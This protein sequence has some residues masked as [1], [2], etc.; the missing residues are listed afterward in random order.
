MCEHTK[1][2]GYLERILSRYHLQ[3]FWLVLVGAFLLIISRRPD[4]ISH[5]QFWA[6]D[7]NFWYSDAYNHGIRSLF[8]LYDGYLVSFYHLVALGSLSVPLRYSPLFFNVSA[9]LLQL[10]PLALINS[11]RLRNIIPYR[12]LAI[13]VSILYVSIPN[14][15]EVFGN[16]TNVQ[17][18]LGIASFLVLVAGASKSRWWFIF[19]L[20]ILVATGLSGP[21]VIMLLIIGAVLWWRERTK[22]HKRN[23]LILLGLATLQLISIFILSPFHRVGGQSGASLHYFM[24][25]VV[26]QIFIGSILGQNHVNMFYGHLLVLVFLLA[27]GLTLIVYAIVHGPLW[28]KLMNLFALLVLVSMLVSLKPLPGVNLWSSLT[29]PGIGQ[30]YWYIPMLSWLMTLLWLLLAAKSKLLKVSAGI[31]LL[32]LAVI[33]ISYSWRMAPLPNMNFQV[34]ASR[35]QTLPSGSKYSIPINPTGWKVTL[36]KK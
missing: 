6:E 30:R 24:E 28:L 35:F 14:A 15:N 3:I 17:W 10:S 20:A 5:P 4:L 33:G 7:G 21:L 18:H 12:S 29:S 22:Q 36:Y 31:L 11:N 8:Y 23:L 1:R 26:G 25:M 13:G 27:V 9:L 19:D 32:L 34:Y 16:L 2:F